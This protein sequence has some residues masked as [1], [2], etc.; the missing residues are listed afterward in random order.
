LWSKHVDINPGDREEPCQGMMKPI[1]V[2]SKKG[3]YRILLR[4]TRC[5]VE[6]WNK[7][8]KH[9][10]FEILLQIMAEKKGPR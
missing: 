6:R 3:E 2:E 8:S 4:C 1:E 7:A 9:D 5:Q 10:D